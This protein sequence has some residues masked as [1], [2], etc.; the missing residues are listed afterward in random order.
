MYHQIRRSLR[1]DWKV[2][3]PG[4]KTR[5][6]RAR[7][8]D[9]IEAAEALDV[10]LKPVSQARQIIRE[11]PELSIREQRGVA[12]PFMIIDKNRICI[13]RFGA[14]WKA[15]WWLS[16]YSKRRKA[17][18]SIRGRKPGEKTFLDWLDKRWLVADEALDLE[19]R[20]QELV[21]LL[22]AGLA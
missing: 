10:G 3:T 5:T 7:K 17:I 18:L 16:E 22:R 14:R 12:R 21:E 9:A 11:W 6:R 13:K 1:G 2:T 8:K 4:G 15:E 19:E 20:V